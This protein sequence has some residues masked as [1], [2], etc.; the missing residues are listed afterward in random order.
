MYMSRSNLSMMTAFKGAFHLIL[1]WSPTKQSEGSYPKK[2]LIVRRTL[3]DD[4]RCRHIDFTCP[5]LGDT[6]LSLSQRDPNSARP[7]R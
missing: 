5:E 6:N 2:Y 3:A 4:F 7:T 1:Q